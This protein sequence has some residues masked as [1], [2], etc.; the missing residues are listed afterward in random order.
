MASTLTQKLSAATGIK[1]T[2]LDLYDNSTLTSLI[3]FVGTAMGSTIV[4]S[5]KLINKTASKK[6]KSFNSDIAIIGMS[7]RFPGADDIWSF[8]DNLK[9]GRT[10][11]TFLSKDFLREKGI[12]S[13]IVDHP[14]Y[15]RVAYKINDADKFD[16]KFWGIGRTEASVMDPQH[17]VFIET[18][19][20]AVENSGYAPKAGL[21]AKPDSR[22]GVFASAGIDGY[23]VHHL[24]GGALN[25]PLEPGQLFM[26]EVASEKDY[27]ATRV[28]YLMNLKG[29]SVNV[30][31]ACSSAL[32]A[33]SQACS[34]ITVGE[35]DMAIAGGAAINFPNMGY[36]YQDGLI[37]SK[38]GYVRPLD[39]SAEGTAFGDSVGAVVLKRLEDAERDNDH[40][41]G[42]I[43]GFGVSNDGSVKAG[44]AAPSAAGQSDCISKAHAM[45]EI[46]PNDVSYIEMHAT[47]TL[48][49]DGIEA[50]GL[51]QSFRSKETPCAVGSV[52][53][54]IG[55][56]NGA[57]GITGFI[58][59]VMMA[60][61]KTLVPTANF[62]KLN[63][64][65]EF[66]GTPFFVNTE[67]KEWQSDVRCAGVSSFGIGGTNAHIVLTNYDDKSTKKSQ[68]AD[69]LM[70]SAKSKE[71]LKNTIRDLSEFLKNHGHYDNH[72]IHDIAYTL[73]TGRVVHPVRAAVLV[74]ENQ[75][76]PQA[77]SETVAMIDSS[78]IIKPASRS[79]IVT[80]MCPGQGSQYLGMAKGLYD[81]IPLFR[82][83][84][85]EVAEMFLFHEPDVDIRKKLFDSEMTSTQ[86]NESPLNVQPSLF[87]VEYSI[88]TLLIHV[89]IVPDSLAGHSIGE[90]VA[91]V[92]GGYISL[93][94]AVNIVFIRATAT[95][96]VVPPGTMLSVGLS[97]E[98][99][100]PYLENFDKLWI[101]AQNSP[102]H[103]VV[104]GDISQAKELEIKLKDDGIKAAIL[105][106][107]RAFHSPM[108][109]KAGEKLSELDI[110]TIDDDTTKRIPVASNVTGSWISQPS[111]MNAEYWKKHMMQ[112]VRWRDCCAATIRTV[113]PT[114]CIEVG[115]GSTLSTLS[116]RCCDGQEYKPAFEQ[117]MRH[118]R[119]D[120]TVSSDTNTM[121]S[122][123]GRLWCI[124]IK[125]NW[126]LWNHQLYEGKV[127]NCRKVSL[128]GYAFEK[129]SF[130]KNPEASVYVEGRGA[131]TTTSAPPS[132]VKDSHQISDGVRDEMLIRFLKQSGKG[133][134]SKKTKKITQTLTAYCLPYAG[135]S[136][137]SYEK[138][139]TEYL[140]AGL[141][142][143]ALELPGRGARMSESLL[144]NDDTDIKEIDS[145]TSAI[146]SDC[147][148]HSRPYVLVGKSMG[149][150]LT[151]EL[152]TK[153][154]KLSH[155]NPPLG[156]IIAGRAPVRKVSD[157]PDLSNIGPEELSDYSL[158]PDSLK[159]SDAW[160]S[161]FLPL[162]KSD[163]LL[164]MRTEI[165]LSRSISSSPFEIPQNLTLLS[166]TSDS[167]FE[168]STAP[169]WFKN[170]CQKGLRP[171]HNIK[172]LPGGH[173]FLTNNSEEI[174]IL[175]MQEAMQWIVKKKTDELLEYSKASI[176]AAEDGDDNYD[177]DDDE[178]EIL[179]NIEWENFPVTPVKG[180]VF[181]EMIVPASSTS[182]DV[183]EILKN[184]EK[185]ILTYNQTDINS[186]EIAEKMCFSLIEAI[187]MYLQDEN[188]LCKEISIQL[189][190]TPYGGII[191]GMTK[192]IP[193]EIPDIEIK[194][195]H[196]DDGCN[197]LSIRDASIIFNCAVNQHDVLVT[198]DGQYKTPK[199]KRIHNN[200]ISNLTISDTPSVIIVTGWTGGLG[201]EVVNML[202]QKLKKSK[203]ILLSRSDKDLTD[204]P[205]CIKERTVLSTY[206]NMIEVMRLNLTSDSDLV[207]ILHLAGFLQDGLVS[208][209]TL[210][211]MMKVTEPKV[212]LLERLL[213]S[214]P[215]DITIK[216]L[217]GFSSTSSLLGYPG[218]SNYCAANGFLDNMAQSKIHNRILKMTAISW[219][220]WGEIGMA[221][222]GTKAYDVAVKE[223]DC[224]LQTKPALNCLA[225]VLKKLYNNEEVS[226]QYAVCDVDWEVSPWNV[227]P[228]VQGQGYFT[229]QSLN[230][231]TKSISNDK[232]SFS[233]KVSFWIANEVGRSS[234]SSIIDEDIASLGLDS[235]DVVQLRNAFVKE[236]KLSA[237]LSYFTKPNLTV[238]Q[239][240][241]SL[242]NFEKKK[243]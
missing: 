167:I 131:E 239:L 200:D 150:L 177:D 34:A 96:R 201:T 232:E 192:S 240:H 130:W 13:E 103:T 85:D 54:N 188:C 224:P 152:F 129:T 147:A 160:T 213:S 76:I 68:G 42:V 242:V 148:I 185:V 215:S 82:E 106:V 149:G 59:T 110:T 6:Q 133:K 183:F 184:S 237:P 122:L 190:M 134:K 123:L 166:A 181:T 52:K 140:S 66:E 219:G 80:F 46:N 212:K 209:Q 194:R 36:L 121:T 8:F 173:D 75:I 63:K 29:P 53:G 191:S 22:V 231:T 25:N 105:H 206:E 174:A 17:R 161:Y 12:S 163:L 4:D 27:I 1:I 10:T 37:Y 48:V 58:K 104:S 207:G 226:S 139:G 220:P 28:S 203:F 230:K 172:Y 165:R 141:D 19:W 189:P 73:R 210:E 89:G 107:N 81:D 238:L 78:R 99:T 143:V 109:E 3:N 9:E 135:G 15:T 178:D 126:D 24:K 7:G 111:E 41:W 91:A 83:T 94:T 119:S 31:S 211:K 61:Y 112:Q 86:F 56:A 217:I 164:D 136:A 72:N 77:L 101:A 79:P 229:E 18:A 14:D 216:Y 235:L 118:A 128:P 2:V 214:I 74:K 241:S 198:S 64:K 88:A 84:F 102:I 115:P 196:Y 169:Q 45:S 175:A 33:I 71:S 113:K 176:S 93:K 26:T 223:G 221:R 222:K 197:P 11:P 180:S 50:K 51:T 208:N 127:N 16:A 153:L 154:K 199:L 187:Q 49:G 70:F 155:S 120:P 204:V 137:R 182:T 90:Y 60:K 35:C 236:F 117:S 87:A 157:I 23:L 218:Q 225:Y 5:S 21:Q 233:S 40:I 67:T 97:E 38:D 98:L 168:C 234:W 47:G 32:V 116:S 179:Y 171:N 30:N 186:A 195:L 243:N 132:K 65:V 193:F 69:L 57:A 142:I 125:V 95:M 158:A 44:Y 228:I 114:V 146:I 108:M 43:R 151:I 100:L 39:E 156:V 55:H 159:S 162:L 170:K 92:L 20:N 144:S 138:W 205:E 227:L 145:L 124:G 62:S 202:G